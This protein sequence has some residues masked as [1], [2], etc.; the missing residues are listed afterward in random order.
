[1][2]DGVNGVNMVTAVNPVVEVLRKDSDRVTI[3]PH[4]TEGE[5][6]MG[7]SRSLLSAS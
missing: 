1:M 5:I 2:E 3:H 4:S 7:S 6:V